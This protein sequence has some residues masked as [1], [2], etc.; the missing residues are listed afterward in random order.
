MAIAAAAIVFRM[1]NKTRF[2]VK[3]LYQAAG[4]LDRFLDQCQPPKA[5]VRMTAPIH[6]CQAYCRHGA[7]FQNR[8][9]INRCEFL[10]IFNNAGERG[11]TESS[12]CGYG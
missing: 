1:E 5:P 4:N 9:R 10:C 6:D 8:I 11:E 7:A 3:Q 2:G 12:P